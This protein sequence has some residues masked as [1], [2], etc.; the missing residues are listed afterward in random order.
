MKKV[1]VVSVSCWCA[2]GIYVFPCGLGID[3]I[4]K[5][6]IQRQYVIKKIKKQNRIYI[7]QKTKQWVLNK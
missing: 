5:Y 2:M 7:P 4:K 1:T 3:N 6:D